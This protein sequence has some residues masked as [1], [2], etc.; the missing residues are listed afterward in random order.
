MEP[1]QS[2]TAKVQFSSVCSDLCVGIRNIIRNQRVIVFLPN[3]RYFPNTHLR[4][5]KIK[6]RIIKK[7]VA[8]NML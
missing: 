1:H 5:S 7:I 2:V 3:G 4:T 8:F 6:I